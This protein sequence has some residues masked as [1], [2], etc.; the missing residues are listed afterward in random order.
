MGGPAPDT[1]KPG[2]RTG[3]RRALVGRHPRRTL[4]RL[5]VLVAVSALVF[6]VWLLP[7]RTREPSMLPTYNPGRVKLINALA[8][9]WRQPNRGDVVAIRLAGR[10]VLYLK[11]IIGLPGERIEIG[12]GVTHIGGVVL[13][14]PYVKRQTDWT[15]PAVTLL[16]DQYYVVGDNRS[17]PP[18]QHVFGTVERDRIVGKV[19]F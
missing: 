19:L 4:A 17:M 1:Q 15:V 2:D 5:V 14:E 11:R 8:Y 16:A 13:D 12:G 10:R 7:V 3:W 6:G 18:N 9:T